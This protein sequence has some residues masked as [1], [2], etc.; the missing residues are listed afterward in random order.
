MT[1]AL[2][3]PWEALLRQVSRSFY[4]TLRILPGT[5]RPQIGLAYLLARTTDTIADTRIVPLDR[6]RAAL[7]E[8]RSAI[9]A[10][11][12]GRNAEEPDLGELTDACS[13]SA[14]RRLAAERSLLEN[15]GEMISLLGSLTSE[16]RCR[17]CDL[18]E[19]IT[20]GQ[21]ADLALF[22]MACEDRIVALESE[23]DLEEYTYRVAGCVGEFWTRVCRTHLFPRADLDETFLLCSG[24]RF[25]KGLQLVNI[26]RDLPEDLRQGRC[27][28]PS[29]RLAQAGLEP[30][31]LLDPG[32]MG[33]F[34]PLY[35]GY[36][37]QAEELLA[38]GWT[39]TNA[40][41][42]SQV[43]VRLACA[44]PILIGM[45]TL[46]HLRSVNVLDT[47]QRVKVSRGEVRLLMIR[48]VLCYPRQ[49]AWDRLFLQAGA[50]RAIRPL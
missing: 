30:S 11:A 48:S 34:R 33:S 5:I 12:D 3:E 10:V 45:R 15:A 43:R 46:A 41:P 37:R 32:A 17:I 2:P 20:R 19:I 18:L 49:T 22:G 24:I 36:I 47:S 16:D 39:Y 21:D 6:R 25:G 8:M 28:L 31:S 14:G 1:K 38:A 9:R 27:Y 35:A 26:L 4:L 23:D 7:R 13:V 29:R 44:W 50:D 40:L 42:R